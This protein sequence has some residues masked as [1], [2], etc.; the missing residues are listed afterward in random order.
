MSTTVITKLGVDTSSMDAGLTQAVKKIEKAA[1]DMSRAVQRTRNAGRGKDSEEGGLFGSMIGKLAGFTAGLFAVEKLKDFVVGIVD[2]AGALNDMSENLGVSVERLQEMQGVFGESGIGAE[3]F[4][5]AMSSLA[6]NIEQ[7]KGGNEDAIKDFEALGVSLDDLRNLSP[8]EV[9]LKIADAT[10]E[11]GSAGEKTVKLEAVFGKVGKS[12]V[13]AM[14]QGSE[15]IK[16]AGN[17]M[18]I[19]S[20]ENAK[21]LDQLGDDTARFWNGFKAMSGNALGV[22]SRSW[23]H[24]M[25]ELGLGKEAETPFATKLEPKAVDVAAEKAAK[26]KAE[27]ERLFQQEIAKFQKDRE[28]QA[29]QTMLDQHAKR[30]DAEEAL[31]KRQDDA[32]KKVLDFRGKQKVTMKEMLH[33]MDQAQQIGGDIGGEFAAK[34]GQA[35]M[36]LVEAQTQRLL[37]SPAERVAADRE[38]LRL[39]HAQQK[40]QRIVERK[41]REGKA[42]DVAQA[43]QPMNPETALMNSSRD[44]SSAAHALKGL[45]IVAITNQ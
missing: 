25:G 15:A 19:M 43:M 14:S 34:A 41:I 40:A 5:K 45:K 13:G 18:T 32:E 21:A 16:E 8:D 24:T 1:T 11:M 3:K 38:A 20:E 4:G 30:M 10:K 42:V 12:M 2:M 31:A 36:D 44:L 29:E 23:K 26:A 33:L 39:R 7:A 9:L 6:S 35:K 27:Q 28:K 37:M 22:F 17:A